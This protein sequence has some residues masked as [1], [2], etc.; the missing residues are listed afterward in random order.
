V[1]VY[2]ASARRLADF[3]ADHPIAHVLGTHIEQ[4]R[5]PYQDYPRGTVYQP[6]EHVLELSRAHV[7]EL[8]EAF[9]NMATKPQS[10]GLPDFS[11]VVRTPAGARRN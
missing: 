11:I 4:S 6:E 7:L 1:P 8:N 10:V 2:A 5:T 9:R 3:V